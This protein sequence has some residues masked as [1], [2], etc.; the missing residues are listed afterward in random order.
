M[1]GEGKGR[2]EGREGI[3]GNIEEG[4]GEVRVGAAMGE[5]V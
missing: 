3:G 5:G 2:R 1:V 4:G